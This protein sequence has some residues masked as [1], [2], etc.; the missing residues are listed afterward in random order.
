MQ[1]SQVNVTVISLEEKFVNALLANV[2]PVVE[3]VVLC[4]YLMKFRGVG[5]QFLTRGAQFLIKLICSTG[6]IEWMRHTL[7]TW[8][9]G[10]HAPSAP[11]FLHL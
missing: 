10:A 6:H 3:D 5:K 11:W 8:G 2:I 7:K 9:R 4:I 1:R